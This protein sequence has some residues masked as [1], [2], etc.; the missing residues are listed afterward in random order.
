MTPN[1][2]E[3]T[4]SSERIGPNLC[5]SSIDL[6]QPVYR[7]TCRK[8]Y[9]DVGQAQ[10]RNNHGAQGHKPHSSRRQTVPWRALCMNVLFVRRAI[11]Q[12]DILNGCKCFVFSRQTV[13]ERQK[14]LPC[15]ALC[16]VPTSTCTITPVVTGQAPA[17]LKRKKIPEEKNKPCVPKVVCV[18]MYHIIS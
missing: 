13:Q 6:Q 18:C 9:P 15:S 1:D 7:S 8:L 14:G 12:P 17:T 2:R 3:K 16:A 11:D 10:R 5:K 4:H